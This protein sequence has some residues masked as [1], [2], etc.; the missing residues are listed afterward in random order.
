LG[1]ST[2]TA[3]PSSRVTPVPSRRH[4]N[5]GPWS[6]KLRTL[7]QPLTPRQPSHVGGG[8]L[9]D[10]RQQEFIR[11]GLTLGVSARDSRLSNRVRPQRVRRY[12]HSAEAPLS[13]PSTQRLAPSLSVPSLHLPWGN[14]G[15][16]NCT[17]V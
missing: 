9:Q 1:S 10:R 3:G 14:P 8:S 6:G 15:K 13:V 5:T 2:T 17:L 11:R 12:H 4:S 16:F 7:A